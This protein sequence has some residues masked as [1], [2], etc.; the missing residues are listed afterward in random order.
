MPLPTTAT[1]SVC[2]SIANVAVSEWSWV[3][4]SGKG[5]VGIH[6]AEIALTAHDAA[7]K[8]AAAQKKR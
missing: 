7:V 4:E 6:A 3:I 1:D 2:E 8:K 5:W